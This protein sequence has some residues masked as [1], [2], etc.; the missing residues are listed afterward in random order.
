MVKGRKESDETGIGNRFHRG[1]TMFNIK[2]TLDNFRRILVISKKPNREEF[3]QTA[4][5]CAAGIGF[6][7]AIGFI[8]FI[9][10]IMVIG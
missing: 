4:K 8:M 5:I 10:S 6:I 2:E 7:G 3:I 9:V 1:L